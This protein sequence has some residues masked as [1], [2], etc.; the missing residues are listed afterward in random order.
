MQ[1]FKQCTKSG[2]CPQITPFLCSSST[3]SY[4]GR[5][6]QQ[7]FL[8]AILLSNLSVHSLFLTVQTISVGINELVVDLKL[9]LMH[10]EDH[11]D[12]S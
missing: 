9:M 2:D 10:L 5:P 1:R 4:T 12:V 11:D 8:S 7:L 6:C 3:V